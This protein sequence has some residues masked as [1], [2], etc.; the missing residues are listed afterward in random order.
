MSGYVNFQ[1]MSVTVLQVSIF[2][3]QACFNMSNMYQC[4]DIRNILYD[5]KS[6]MLPPIFL[7]CQGSK[8]WN[9]DDILSLKYRLFLFISEYDMYLTIMYVL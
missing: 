8:L 5:C 6:A 4:L 3:Q 7:K 1:D 9:I 2:T